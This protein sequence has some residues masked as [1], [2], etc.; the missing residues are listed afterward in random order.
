MSVQQNNQTEQ[1]FQKSQRAARSTVHTGLNA[2]KNTVKNGE[3]AVKAGKKAV[4][5]GV[6]VGKAVAEMAKSIITF[7]IEN[8]LILVILLIIVILLIAV[9]LSLDGGWMRKDSDN[10]VGH[11]APYLYEKDKDNA[12]EEI[13]EV[14]SKSIKEG[15]DESIKVAEEACEDYIEEHFSDHEC[16]VEYEILKDD[17]KAVATYI[18]PWILAVN[19]AIQYEVNEPGLSLYGEVEEKNEYNTIG[20]KFKNVV[21]EYADTQL[22]YVDTDSLNA[23]DVEL[24]TVEIEEPI[25]NEITGEQLFDINGNPLVRTYEKEVYQGTVYIGIG[26][27]IGDYK[28]DDIEKA[29]ENIYENRKKFTSTTQE[30][31]AEMVDEYIHDILLDE[32]GTREFNPWGGYGQGSLKVLLEYLE[33]LDIDWSNL[34]LTPGTIE[35]LLNLGTHGGQMDPVLVRLIQEAEANGALTMTSHTP[36]GGYYCTEWVHLFMYL[37]YGKDFN[38]NPGRDGGDGNGANIARTLAMR[39]DEWEMS[40]VPTAGAVFSVQYTNG[41]AGHVGMITKVEGDRVWWC[42]GNIGGSGYNTRINQET[43][44]QD[45]MT[46]FGGPVHFANHK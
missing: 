36:G 9:V 40:P 15:Y 45:F 42:D 1:D 22:F 31:Y 37:A 25:L 46:R 21:K 4:E 29:V 43:T 13:I 23:D 35:A 11:K 5:V 19:G 20:N 24:V 26:Y 2:A 8:P 32:I 18:T 30:Q 12:Y 27:Y 34:R 41:G 39:Y 14:V 28:V 38:T 3:K 44:L 10:A 7:L 16:E 17:Q 33:L 6:K